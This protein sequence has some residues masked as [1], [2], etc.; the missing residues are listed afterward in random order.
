MSILTII[1]F[2]V[3]FSLLILVHELGHFWVAKR[4]GVKVEEFGIGLPPRIWGIKKKNTIYSINWI[5]FGG[6]VRV[7]GEGG[8]NLEDK[9]SLKSQNYLVQILFTIGGVLMNFATAY[10]V[11]MIGFW[12]GMPPMATDVT[13]YVVDQERITSQVLVL[14]VDKESPAEVAG[15]Q[16][17]DLILEVDGTVLST[18]EDLQQALTGKRSA[19]LLLQRDGETVQVTSATIFEENRQII[20]VLADELVERVN[21]VWWQVPL[22]ALQELWNLLK[23]IAI[24]IVGILTK[25]VI[26]ASVPES[27]AGPVGIAKITAQVVRLGFLSVLQFIIFL[28]VNLGL[29]NIVPFPALDGGRLVF[30][31]AEVF[32]GGKRIKPVVENAIHSIGFL[33]LLA[34]I[35]VVTYRDILKLF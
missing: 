4:A 15:I 12:L 19:S 7:K 1:I 33:L 2:V 32:R 9:D 29:I 13:A 22:L 10:V 6:F 30:L 24:A 21:Y 3:I 26:T 25:L 23:A 5:P 16:P 20:G 31:I 35:F 18:V 28:S 17:G 34:F 27:I 11:L 8:E 14:H